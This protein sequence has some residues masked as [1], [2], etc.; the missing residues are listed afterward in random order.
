MTRR[1][2]LRVLGLTAARGTGA[3]ARP[4]A[5]AP[6]G[7]VKRGPRGRAEHLRP[8]HLTVGRN[9]HDLHRERLRRADRAA[10]PGATDTRACP[11]LEAAE[12]H[13]LAVRLRKGVKSHCDDFTPIGQVP[14]DRARIPRPRRP[15][16]PQGLR[17]P[18]A[19]EIVTLTP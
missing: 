3:R 18:P 17:R 2:A 15:S 10:T 14:L 4:A 8:A 16:A 19:P 5:A 9:T 6:T 13:H 1:D 12:P 7:E 11:V